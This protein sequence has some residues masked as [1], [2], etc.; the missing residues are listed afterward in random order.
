MSLHYYTRGT[1]FHFDENLV[2]FFTPKVPS[3][4][5]NLSKCKANVTVAAKAQFWSQK[6]CMYF[7]CHFNVPY[8]DKACPPQW[9]QGILKL[10][11]FRF[12]KKVLQWETVKFE[13]NHYLIFE[14]SWNKIVQCEEYSKMQNIFGP[15]WE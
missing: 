10:H 8:F 14:F 9:E 5:S 3:S 2:E 12:L 7:G 1:I 13:L 15:I 4:L 11:Y 6:A